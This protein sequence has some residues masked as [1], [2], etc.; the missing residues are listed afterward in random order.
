MN[1]TAEN[2]YDE[3]S[4][5][6]RNNPHAVKM[7][8]FDKLQLRRKIN[9]NS[10]EV[11]NI[12]KRTSNRHLNKLGIKSQTSGINRYEWNDNYMLDSPSL[13]MCNY[14]KSSPFSYKTPF[15]SLSKLHTYDTQINHFIKSNKNTSTTAFDE[16]IGDLQR[17]NNNFVKRRTLK[18]P[19]EL[20][21]NEIK[22]NRI[23]SS[24]PAF[25]QFLIKLKNNPD[26]FNK[27]GN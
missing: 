14:N 7:I 15:T 1:N 16:I 12:I 22:N 20:F 24:S 3:L 2:L 13:H 27:F 8:P 18:D 10:N 26:S 5:F 25:K 23:I 19:N 4:R 11:E 9:N 17:F 21:T 6:Q